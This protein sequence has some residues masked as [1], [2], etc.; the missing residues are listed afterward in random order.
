[1]EQE[2]NW[3]EF[4]SC[5]LLGFWEPQAILSPPRNEFRLDRKSPSDQRHPFDGQRQKNR[6]N[7]DAVYLEEK[8]NSQNQSMG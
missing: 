7:I 8:R 5:G 4:T 1:M 6:K 3:I 2:R